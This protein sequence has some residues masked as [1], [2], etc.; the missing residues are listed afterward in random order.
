MTA[1]GDLGERLSSLEH[2]LASSLEQARTPLALEEIVLAMSAGLGGRAVLP[3]VVA[4]LLRFRDT[5]FT[6]DANGRWR[7][8]STTHQRIIGRLSRDGIQD[9]ASGRVRGARRHTPQARH[10]RPGTFH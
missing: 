3:E 10:H 9:L 6:V 1:D 8:T 4:F 7:R 2:A 5:Q